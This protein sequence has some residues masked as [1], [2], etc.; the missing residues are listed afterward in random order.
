MRELSGLIAVVFLTW[1]GSGLA[2]QAGAE[3]TNL[4]GPVT[5]G[6]IVKVLQAQQQ[7][8]AEQR[9]LIEDQ[10]RKIV[11][12]RN[13]IDALNDDDP[14]RPAEQPVKAPAP[15]IV[16]MS[17]SEEEQEEE[18]K[19][20][21]KEETT[22]QVEQAQ[23]DDPARD[24]LRDFVGS[25]RLPGTRAALRIGGFVKATTVNSFDPLEVTDRFIVGSIPVR[26]EDSAAE[27]EAAITADQSRLNFDLREP[28]DYGVLRAFIEG[29]FDGGDNGG[30]F[31]LRHAFGQWNRVLAGQTWSAFVDTDATPEEIDFEGLNGRVNVR[32]AQV[33]L[34]PKI[35]ERYEF[36]LSAEDPNPLV[37]NGDGVTRFPD[38]VATARLNWGNRLHFKVGGLYR[39]VRANWDD[40]PR[41]TEKQTGWGLQV[42]GRFDAG[43]FDERDSILFQ[44]NGG[45]GIGRYI[46]DL[47]SVGDFD[48]VFDAN[49]NLELI[50]VVSGYVSGQ[51]WWGQTMRSNLTFGFVSLNNPGFVADDFYKKTF[52]ISGNLMWSPTPRIT[53]GGELLWGQRENED[54]AEGNASQVQFAARYNF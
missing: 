4:E 34:F 24:E 12:L 18:Q 54:G 40:A 31:R 22:E 21:K 45:K 25:V 1:S 38:I 48:G 26:D 17:G 41:S 14:L 8:L 29:D 10:N 49:G 3:D 35:G 51:H 28:T 36:E 33:R 39:Q 52:R 42:S 16:A 27:A 32:Q 50:D 6:D 15:A 7:E 46:N 44:V 47:R 53:L 5:L 13:E 20:E 30:Q 23:R 43:W 37:D 2:A 11:R 19:A 9:E